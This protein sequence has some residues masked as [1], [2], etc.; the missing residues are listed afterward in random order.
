MTTEYNLDYSY[1]TVQI[2]LKNQIY[3]QRELASLRHT[4]SDHEMTSHRT[5]IYLQIIY[6]DIYREI[7]A[8]LQYWHNTMKLIRRGRRATKLAVFVPS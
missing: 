5:K 7:L 6:E 2:F 1:T 4:N 8:V 3:A